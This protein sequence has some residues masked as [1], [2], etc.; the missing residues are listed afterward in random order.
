MVLYNIIEGETKNKNNNNPYIVFT[1]F[2]NHCL[3]PFDSI[4]LRHSKPLASR[5]V[6]ED[7]R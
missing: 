3:K 2:K 4:L 5:H 6:K 7:I 1:P